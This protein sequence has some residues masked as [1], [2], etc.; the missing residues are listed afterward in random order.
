LTHINPTLNLSSFVAAEKFTSNEN[1]YLLGIVEQNNTPVIDYS[2]KKNPIVSKLIDVI[3]LNQTL[4]SE[5][6]EQLIKQFS[7]LRQEITDDEVMLLMHS[8]QSIPHG[9]R[10][11]REN[12]FAICGIIDDI[13]RSRLSSQIEGSRFC[14]GQF[15]W[16]LVILYYKLSVARQCLFIYEVASRL[17]KNLDNLNKN[18]FLRLLFVINIRRSQ[19]T[20]LQSKEMQKKFSIMIP[21]MSANEVALASAAFFKTQTKITDP[22]L[23]NMMLDKVSGSKTHIDC[24]ALS[25]I[26]KNLKYGHIGGTSLQ[27]R[28]F[29]SEWKKSQV[30]KLNYMTA[31][32]LLSVSCNYL[33]FNRD[34]A[35]G[36]LQLLIEKPYGEVR[37]KDIA[38][39]LRCCHEF[40]YKPT[41]E[42]FQQLIED[43]SKSTDVQAY[44][45]YFLVF[46]SLIASFEVHPDD[47]IQRCFEKSFVKQV[48][49]AKDFPLHRH[50]LTLHTILSI[51]C[52]P[53]YK[54][55]LLSDTQVNSASS[56]I[57][58]S[59]LHRLSQ[60]PK[61][62]YGNLLE[63]SFMQMFH[64]AKK[65]F[66]ADR[67]LY[68]F[69][70]P[71]TF[72]PF[73][74]ILPE[75]ED[76]YWLRGCPLEPNSMKG[77]QVLNIKSMTHFAD[78]QNLR[79]RAY[80][81][82]QLRLLSKLGVYVHNF[83]W[84]ELSNPGREFP[85][86]L[87]RLVQNQT[88]QK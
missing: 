68:S 12:F 13:S 35:D 23:V 10:P 36:A 74:V 56:A 64:Q 39:V 6:N 47:L 85:R 43:V 67:V 76:A 27:I 18:E 1:D 73:I 3:R 54:S 37:L 86:R 49:D 38:E 83:H 46:L 50:L 72:H 25:A 63:Y 16:D 24:L 81:A 52:Y 77:A 71:Y 79:Y 58:R 44:P 4:E 26:L 15:V 7:Q 66:G 75:G 28:K 59:D 34:I 62:G 40:N 82:T 19:L 17:I 20:D 61:K 33:V 45:H 55:N 5:E 8:L 80:Y 53:K 41:D 51:D 57:D 78:T 9:V 21:K 42:V 29:I 11:K 87:K 69:I 31:N 30:V 14:D 70:L 2:I 65:A 84:T 48:L 88:V 32:H 22:I 60:P